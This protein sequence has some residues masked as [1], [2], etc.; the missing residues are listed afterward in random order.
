M[1]AVNGYT[2]LTTVQSVFCELFILPVIFLKKHATM[3]HGPDF[4]LQ[5]MDILLED[6]MSLV[7]T[8]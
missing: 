7:P 6:F 8:Q 3:M 2:V 5:I 4:I 1:C